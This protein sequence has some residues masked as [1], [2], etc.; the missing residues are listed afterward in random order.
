[1]AHGLVAIFTRETNLHEKFLI[2]L[3][4]KRLFKG[5]LEVKIK[6]AFRDKSEGFLYQNENIQVL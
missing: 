2:P 5:G 1:M 4:G 6:W 3:Y